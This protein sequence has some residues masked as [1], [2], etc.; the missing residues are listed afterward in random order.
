MKKILTAILIVL[1]SVIS[2][3]AD[4]YDTGTG[5]STAKDCNVAAYYPIGKLCQDTDDGKL[6]KGT[7]SAVEEISGLVTGLTNA[8]SVAITGGTINGTTIGGTTPAAGTFTSITADTAKFT[9]GAA[10]NSI[11][12]SDADG[13]AT[14]LPS[15]ANMISFLG[16]ATYAA[17]RTN[18]G[19]WGVS[20][21]IT[22][23]QLICGETTAGTNLLKSCGAKTTNSAT[24]GNVIVQTG[25]NTTGNLSS[26]DV[27]TSGYLAGRMKAVI[28]AVPSG[29]HD[30]SDDAATMTDAGIDMGADALIGMTVYNI[31]DGS[32]C[33][34]TDNAAT[35]IT[36]TL[37][38]GTGNDWDTND[39]W[40]VGPGPTQSGSVFY[41]G[42]AGTVRHPATAG[43]LAGY[44]TTA[45]AAVIINPASDS[46]VITNATASAIDAGDCVDS[47]ATAGSYL[48]LHNA[49][50][51]LAYAL[52]KNGTYTDGGAD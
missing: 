1:I 2:V 20:G 27:V 32:S 9:T 17:A 23:E 11:L 50:A 14:W 25:S 7:G 42:S 28:I 44:Y 33:T 41:V 12:K 46:M 6:Y 34:I 36:C 10:A 39:V 38:G 21:I 4:I 49:S 13:D 15:S 3:Y 30:G 26:E 43:Y 5:V 18:L 37:T 45:A 47:P 19:T 35:T 22:D 51:T 24:T 29:V 52:G 40:Q 8:A 16:S 31:T 48:F